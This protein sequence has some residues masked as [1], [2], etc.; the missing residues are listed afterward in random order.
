MP[1]R[2]RR[3]VANPLPA[4]TAV[5]TAATAEATAAATAEAAAAEAAAAET[6]F[7][8]AP[9]RDV[10]QGITAA[11]ADTVAKNAVAVQM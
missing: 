6:M 4:A 7:A 5:A 2:H 11:T 9:I 1:I 3:P 8:A 10:R